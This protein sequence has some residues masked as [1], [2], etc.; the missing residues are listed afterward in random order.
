MFDKKICILTSGGDCSGLNSVIRAAFIRATSLGYEVLGSKRGAHGLSSDEPGD[1]I[2][3]DDSV[4]NDE[5]MLT[6]SGSILLSSSQRVK[7]KNGEVCSRK[8]EAE[9]F[10][11]AYK[12][13][14]LSGVVFIG[15]DGS[16]EAISHGMRLYEDMG[17]N[18]SIVPKTIDNDVSMTDAAIGFP[19]VVEVVSD[20]IDNIRTTAMSHERVMVVEVM[21]RDAGFIALHSG[22]ASG[23]DVILIPELMYNNE[24]LLAKIRAVHSRKGYCI[25]IV[26]EA[27]ENDN[28]KHGKVMVGDVQM[29]KYSGIGD[30]IASFIRSNGFD[31]RLVRLGHVQRGGK[32]AVMDRIIGSGFGVE[33]VEAIHRNSGVIMVSFSGGKI[34][35]IPA[36]I[37]VKS[38]TRQIEKDDIYLKIAAG[39]GVYV[40]E[41]Q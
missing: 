5:S 10:A 29:A 33:A 22:I 24:K 40:G 16:I 41:A 21:G 25:V 8:E 34:I 37:I 19:T 35:D 6:R 32:T 3:L 1:V 36:E 23:A 30:N 14:G 17:M 31:S 39:L 15:G 4:C 12:E 20:A 2:V 18:I 27:V 26:A 9:L 38:I 13:L 7:N 28:L 11:N